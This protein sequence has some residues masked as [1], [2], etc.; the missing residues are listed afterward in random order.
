MFTVML[1]VFMLSAVSTDITSH[2]IPN[3]LVI[4]VLMLALVEQLSTD[5]LIGIAYWVAGLAVCLGVFLPF[6]A[7]GGMGA[8]DVKL[9]AAVGAFLGPVDAAITSLAVLI[10]GLPLVAVYVAVRYANQHWFA[11]PATEHGATTRIHRKP[12]PAFDIHEGRK[13]RIPYAAALAAGTFF[14]L[15]WSGRIDQVTG[16]LFP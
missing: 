14:G 10:A 3:T 11:E 5:P 4:M 6:Y 2:R 9:M 15:W 13:Q 12:D 16:V 1:M 8:G 7:G